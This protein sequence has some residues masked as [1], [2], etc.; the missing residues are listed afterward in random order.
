MDKGVIAALVTALQDKK[1]G[2]GRRL[3]AGAV[4][5]IGPEAKEAIPTLVELLQVDEAS[6]PAN[7][8]SL[9]GAAALAL[10]HMGPEA[11]VAVRPLLAVVTNRAREGF[12]RRHAIEALGAIGPAA[13]EAVP[14]LQEISR[15]SEDPLATAAAAAL[16]M[17]QCEE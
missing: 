11:R 17:I 13:R 4:A 6:E 1:S 2:W 5:Q 16:K 10:K 8:A 12:T 14:A 15:Q 9:R 7:S 3:I